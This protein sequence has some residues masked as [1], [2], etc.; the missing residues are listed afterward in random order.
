MVAD[1]QRRDEGVFAVRMRMVSVEDT[2]GQ[3]GD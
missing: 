1:E 3:C 2:R